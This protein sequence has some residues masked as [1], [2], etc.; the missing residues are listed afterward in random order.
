MKER[1]RDLKGKLG[2]KRSEEKRNSSH[3]EFLVFKNLRKSEGR[4]KEAKK[5]NYNR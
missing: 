1:E 4:A 5:G 3:S 2:G